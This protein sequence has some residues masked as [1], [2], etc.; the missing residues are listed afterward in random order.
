MNPVLPSRVGKRMRLGLVGAGRWGSRYITTCDGLEGVQLALVASR[1]PA[2]AQRAPP[3]CEV[4]EDWH[5]ALE[6]RRLDGLILATPPAAHFEMALACVRTG[7]P[8]L[9]EKPLTLDHGQAQRLER[10]ASD[11]DCL[12]MVDHTHLFSSAYEEL[13]ARARE[14]EG[15]LRVRGM[16]GN[17]GPF[18]ADVSALW[19]WGPHDLS[20]TLDLLALPPVAASARAISVGEPQ[21]PGKMVIHAEL[22]F[23][24]GAHAELTF[25]NLMKARRRIFEV[26]GVNGAL[27]YDDLAADKLIARDRSGVCTPVRLSRTPPLTRAVL[28]FRDAIRAGTREHPSLP[29]A[30]RVVEALHC[31]DRKLAT[32]PTPPAGAA[33]P[34]A[35]TGHAAAGGRNH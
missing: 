4:V 17:N 32:P 27:I 11:F 23:P 14:L 1:N 16:G 7:L 2:T 20:M 10:A 33:A 18:R 34:A 3:G 22:G 9:V 31:I 6:P 26:H 28:A 35:P 24:D 15:P 29:L 25:G 21:E 5:S 8:V 19:D 13:K 12:V 30:V